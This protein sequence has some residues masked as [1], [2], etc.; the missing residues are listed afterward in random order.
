MSTRRQFKA[1]KQEVPTLMSDDGHVTE[2]LQ[3]TAPADLAAFAEQ[4]GIE[5]DALHA[6]S[7]GLQ[8]AVAIAARSPRLSVWAWGL[9]ADRAAHVAAQITHGDRVQVQALRSHQRR[10]STRW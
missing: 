6:R 4:L 2:L 3:A 9:R 8:R 10:W 7:R 5:P 1:L